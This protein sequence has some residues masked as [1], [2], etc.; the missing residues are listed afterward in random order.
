LSSGLL[1]R[2]HFCRYQRLGGT[3]CLQRNFGGTSTVCTQ[4][5]SSRHRIT[6]CSPGTS[7]VGVAAGNREAQT[8]PFLIFG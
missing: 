2:M 5:G 3:Y 6:L 4:A 1:R 7:V 8:N